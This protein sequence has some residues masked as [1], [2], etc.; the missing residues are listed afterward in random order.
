MD[1]RHGDQNALP[2]LKKTIVPAVIG[3]VIIVGA[4]AVTSFVVEGLVRATSF[5]VII[6]LKIQ[7]AWV[8][9]FNKTRTLVCPRRCSMHTSLCLHGC[10]HSP[11]GRGGERHHPRRKFVSTTRMRHTPCLLGWR[12]TWAWRPPG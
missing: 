10:G 12:G 11:H 7:V 3:I 2:R 8:F 4:Y 1:D 5:A 6:F 9:L